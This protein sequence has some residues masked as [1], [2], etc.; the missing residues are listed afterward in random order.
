MDTAYPKTDGWA[1]IP[2]CAGHKASPEGD[3]IN[4]K[5]GRIKSQ[6][7]AANGA[8][9]VDIGKST[10]LVHDLV[11]RAHFGHPLVKGYRVKHRNGD[12]G[13]NRIDNLVWAGSPQGY[14]LP[15]PSEYNIR[16]EQEYESVQNERQALI[17]LMQS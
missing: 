12:L 14:D 5:T 8:R 13:D 4:S 3:I 10:R 17:E 15:S 16:L 7:R 1:E 2:G 9:I 11:A 6:R